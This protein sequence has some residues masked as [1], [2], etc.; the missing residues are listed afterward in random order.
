MAATRSRSAVAASPLATRSVQPSTNRNAAAESTS[1]SS[2][3]D[4][5]D[6]SQ[7]SCEINH[8]RVPAIRRA[9]ITGCAR[10]HCTPRGEAP[11]TSWSSRESL[12][13]GSPKRASES[14]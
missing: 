14:R 12:R 6:A 3:Y 13:S 1:K 5:T 4:R 10:S 8:S 9:E 7:R 2:R 11:S